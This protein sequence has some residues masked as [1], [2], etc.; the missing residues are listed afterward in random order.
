LATCEQR[1]LSSKRAA[2]T[3]KRTAADFNLY[4][5]TPDPRHI[6][7]AQFRDIRTSS[8]ET[9]L[10]PIFDNPSWC[11]GY[12]AFAAGCPAGSIFPEFSHYRRT[13]LNQSARKPDEVTR[14]TSNLSEIITIDGPSPNFKPF[15]SRRE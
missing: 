3:S 15:R 8:A 6:S 4:Y 7:H 2:E 9:A 10:T 5:A 14:V 1:C 13:G 12:G 11:R